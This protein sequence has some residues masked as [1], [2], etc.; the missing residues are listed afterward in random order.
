[1]SKIQEVYDGWKNLVYPSKISEG[2]AKV[3]IK[4]CVDCEFFTKR[5]TCGKCGCYMPAKVRS[6]RSKTK[7][8]INKW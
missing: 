7:C 3:R 2:V 1:M 6:L 5:K 8:P 4:I